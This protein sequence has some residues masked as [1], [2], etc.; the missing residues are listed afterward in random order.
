MAGTVYKHVGSFRKANRIGT[1]G[2]QAHPRAGGAKEGRKKGYRVP[3]S[4][5]IGVSVR[6]LAPL[7]WQVGAGVPTPQFT[8]LPPPRFPEVK[9]TR[10]G[11]G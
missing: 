3:Q 2:S 9:L 8:L 11:G 4:S 10:K 1:V 7:S 5:E 6:C